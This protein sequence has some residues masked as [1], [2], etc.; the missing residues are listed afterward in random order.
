MWAKRALR[1]PE[2][3]NLLQ[4]STVSTDANRAKSKSSMKIYNVNP[5]AHPLPVQLPVYSVS[6]SI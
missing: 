3:S 1:V 4:S 2:A 5:R 6:F